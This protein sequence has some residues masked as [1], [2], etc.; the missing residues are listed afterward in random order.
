MTDDE[1]KRNLGRK[2]RIN[3]HNLDLLCNY[4]KKHFD[5]ALPIS[6]TNSRLMRKLG[7]GNEVALLKI[8]DKAVKLGLLTV[9]SDKYGF[10]HSYDE[11]NYSKLYRI[12]QV[13]AAQIKSIANSYYNAYNNGRREDQSIIIDLDN[14]LNDDNNCLEIRPPE[15][16]II[17]CR[18]KFPA[19]YRKFVY[20]RYP[21]IRFIQGMLAEMNGGLE[22]HEHWFV[23][24]MSV[25]IRDLDDAGRCNFSCRAYS[26]L[27]G[28]RK[29]RRF[30]DELCRDDLLDGYFG[31]CG[32]EEFDLNASIYR[33][34]RSCRD[35]KWYS[36]ATDIYE[37]LRGCPFASREERDAFK[38][39]CM[40]MAFSSGISSACKAYR[41]K[42]NRWELDH[43]SVKEIIEPVGKSVMEFCGQVDTDV[44]LHESCVM[45]MVRHRLFEMGIKSVQ[46]YDCL[47][48]EKDKVDDFDGLI[49]E[50]FNEYYDRYVIN[51]VNSQHPFD[52]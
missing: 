43:G 44:F 48:V 7:V 8:I 12:D 1:I 28:M 29:V 34:V 51:I 25:N 47:F 19:S 40:V 11:Y 21:Q 24:S 45:T 22:D 30:P 37:T 39:I 2:W 15:L 27:C 36:S 18:K 35:G 33:I 3:V 17:S 50:C 46:L 42:F 6:T 14:G 10:N 32:W 5:K 4:Y 41:M 13:M 23:T 16:P 38:G 31:K 52:E 26:E 20:D 49:S 9:V